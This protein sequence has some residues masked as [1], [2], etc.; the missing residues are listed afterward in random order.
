MLRNEDS[1]RVTYAAV[2]IP[3]DESQPQE[4][5]LPDDTRHLPH[6]FVR[7]SFNRHARAAMKGHLY[8]GNCHEGAEGS[9]SRQVEVHHRRGS[10]LAHAT[11]STYPDTIGDHTQYCQSR[12]ERL[13]AAFD[14][15]EV[16]FNV[17]GAQSDRKDPRLE[18]YN[19]FTIREN[20][21]DL[22]RAADHLSRERAQAAHYVVGQRV[23]P[24]SKFFI[25][26]DNWKR[27]VQAINGRGIAEF[28]PRI[29][30]VSRAQS[31]SLRDF[32]NRASGL[33][34]LE[35]KISL[36]QYEFYD[37]YN[38]RHIVQPSIVTNADAV[39]SVFEKDGD[40]LVFGAFTHLPFKARGQTVIHDIR[41]QVESEGQAVRL[42]KK[43]GRQVR[44]YN[45]LHSLGID[46]A[47]VS[48]IEPQRRAVPKKKSTRPVPGQAGL[49]DPQ[50]EV[51]NLH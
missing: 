22:V 26:G 18:G 40:Y 20:L 51:P 6:G 33:P 44:D 48:L 35:I 4:F 46:A 17:I 49:F 32:A 50:P 10:R 9:E 19:V 47:E 42:Y 12:R 23:I 27:M 15:R 14:G 31:E 7:F 39:K 16:R 5:V 25:D 21:S 11:F 13:Q 29:F 43:E 2:F 38:V 41:I 45:A 36:R 30:H 1:T 8:C 28:M 34:E 3:D 37:E 24:H